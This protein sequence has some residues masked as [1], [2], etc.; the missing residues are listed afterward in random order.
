MYLNT[1]LYI[2]SFFFIFFS[3]LGYG[4]ILSHTININNRRSISFGIFG[5]L[6]VFLYTLISYSTHLF[7]AHN[8][9]HN[10]IVNLIG[11]IL[12]LYFYIKNFFFYKKEFFKLLI[13]ILFF[14]T[15][16]IFI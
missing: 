2:F 13:L 3:I 11:I 12:F 5:L 15:W 14:F 1:I 16:P 6:G 7:F 10:L 8:L 4:L 9:I